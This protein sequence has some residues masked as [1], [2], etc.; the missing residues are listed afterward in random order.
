MGNIKRFLREKVLGKPPKKPKFFR[1]KDRFLS[2]YPNYTIGDG[3]YGIPKVFD[4]HEGTS[5]HIGS[6]CSI[7]DN[8]RIYLGGNHIPDWVSTYP[9]PAYIEEASH[10][11]TTESS[12][13]D[14]IIGS[15]V[16]IA[17]NAVILSG[18]TIGHGAIIANSAI[19]TKDVEP[20]SIVGG[21]PARLI[22]YRFEESARRRLMEIAWWKWPLEE[23]FSISP[24]LCSKDL[25]PFF[26][27]CAG[28]Q[29]TI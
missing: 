26:D 27:Y 28:R 4:W 7:A 9:F 22:K 19:V 18:V 12:K 10:I 11:T 16:W 21:N 6:F 17:A 25:D 5:L 8:V 2:R 1:Q 23:I 14:V 29:Q 13:G 15:D 3:S 24:L 20:Y